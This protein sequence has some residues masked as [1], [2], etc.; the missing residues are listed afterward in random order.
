M[1]YAETRKH[2]LQ[3]SART[4]ATFRERLGTRSFRPG[5]L[6]P[7]NC[8]R[9]HLVMHH[10]THVGYTILKIEDWKRLLEEMY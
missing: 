10:G 1:T 5:L 9:L 2:R 6:V 8:V 4:W 7:A 3:K